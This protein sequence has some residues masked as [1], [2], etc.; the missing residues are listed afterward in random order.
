VNT[1]DRSSADDDVQPI[2]DD[3][4]ETLVAW[5]RRQHSPPGY[6]SSGVLALDARLTAAE[7]RLARAV[8]LLRVTMFQTRCLTPEEIEH[9]KSLVAASDATT[10]KQQPNA[11]GVQAPPA[12]GDL[13]T[14]FFLAA[15]AFGERYQQVLR[16]AQLTV[17]I[18]LDRWLDDVDE[19]RCEIERLRAARKSNA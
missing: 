4:R 7:E 18:I 3:E 14:L 9:G 16:S 12:R 8:A 19:V 10:S 6:A 11:D 1:T 2:T 5:A 15:D 13:D 17:D